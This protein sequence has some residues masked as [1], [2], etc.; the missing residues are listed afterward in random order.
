MVTSDRQSAAAIESI[1]SSTQLTSAGGTKLLNKFK[2]IDIP[3]QSR[4]AL[5]SSNFDEVAL[6]TLLTSRFP[7][8]AFSDVL[9][10][11]TE[12]LTQ[13]R[14]I[15]YSI[16]WFDGLSITARWNEYRI[17]SMMMLFLNHTLKACTE[18]MEATAANRDLIGLSLKLSSKPEDESRVTWSGFADLKCCNSQCTSIDE[19]IATF[20]IKMPFSRGGLY[21]SQV[22]QRKQQLLGQAMSLRRLSPAFT[23]FYT[24]RT[25]LLYLLCIM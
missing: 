23:T 20:E 24:L 18:N 21:Q 2:F 5:L 12:K 14:S 3:L 15:I 11:L 7:L 1:V 25:Y 16:T 22:L 6:E 13:L 9:S 4:P 19:A 17:Q 8:L 10:D